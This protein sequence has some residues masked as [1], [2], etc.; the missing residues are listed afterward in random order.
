MVEFL[1]RQ[2][3]GSIVSTLRRY[4]ALLILMAL[5]QIPSVRH[6]CFLFQLSPEIV[7][8][9][10]WTGLLEVLHWFRD[11]HPLYAPTIDALTGEMIAEGTPVIPVAKAEKV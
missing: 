10:L 3:R 9:G 6:F 2:F 8:G 4:I 5:A 1:I 7:A 11:T